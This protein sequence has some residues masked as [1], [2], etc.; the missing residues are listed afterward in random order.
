MNKEMAIV[1][2]PGQVVH[3]IVE[4]VFINV[5]Y[6]QNS[7]VTSLAEPA[8]LRSARF[9]HNGSMSKSAVYK[10]SMPFTYVELISPICLTRLTAEVISAFGIHELFYKHTLVIMEG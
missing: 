4:V 8:Y 9:K 1:T 6:R 5:M 2:Q 10:I 3:I 7:L